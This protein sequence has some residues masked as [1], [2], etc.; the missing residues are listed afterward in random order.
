MLCGREN[1]LEDLGE[2]K[3]TNLLR[4]ICSSCKR[5][6]VK[7]KEVKKSRFLKLIFGHCK[8]QPKGFPVNLSNSLQLAWQT[9]TLN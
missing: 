9:K 4:S 5:R 3:F 6:E 8:S 2:N 7:K 1:L